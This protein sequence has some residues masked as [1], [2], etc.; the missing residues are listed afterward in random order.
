M[1]RFEGAARLGIL[2]SILG[3]RDLIFGLAMLGLILA[4]SAVG[5]ALADTLGCGSFVVVEVFT[6]EG[7]G[8][9]GA[10]E[11]AV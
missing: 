2:M 1:G 11:H 6:G 3:L 7:E 9:R 10:T 8:C 5:G 4:G